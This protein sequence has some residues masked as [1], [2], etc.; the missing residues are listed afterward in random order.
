MKRPDP[1]AAAWLD[2]EPEPRTFSAGPW[3]TTLRGT[4]LED[5]SHRGRYLLSAL[6]VVVRDHDW[7]TVPDRLLTA[8]ATVDEHLRLVLRVEHAGLDAGVRWC[9]TLST[10]GD[11]LRF[12]VDGEVTAAFRRNRV[13]L[14]V[15]HPAEVAGR[16]LQVLHPDG[17]RT[18]TA[19]PVAIAPH[20]PAREV[21]GLVWPV[22]GAE[23]A[24]SLAGDVFEVED[25][26]N[27]TDASFKTYST[28]LDLPFPVA[29]APGDRFTQA[30]ELVVTERPAGASAARA[31]ERAPVPGRSTGTPP[32]P[33]AVA[34]APTGRAVPELQ[35]GACTA[36]GDVR[37]PAPWW[38]GPVLVELDATGRAWPGLL[39]R[40]RREAAGAPLDVRIT[41]QR[42][43]QLDPVLA[44]L[45]AGAAEAAG[46][47]ARVGAY[48]T[49]G[50]VTTP[51]LWRRLRERAGDLPLVG[52]TRAHFTELNRRHG[53]L[54][55]DLPALTFS[56]T[57]QM[58]DTG[59]RQLLESIPVQRATAEQAVRIATGRP[60]HVGPVTLRPRFNAVATSARVP[61]DGEVA[62]GGTGPQHVWQADDPRQASRAFAAWLLASVQAFTVAGVASIT[63][64]ET[65]GPRGFGTL[66][67]AAFPAAEPL[68]RL[69]SAGGWQV[70]EAPLLPGL[71][72]VAACRGGQVLLLA[73]DLSGAGQ[74]LLVAGRPVRVP[75]W[76][77]VHHQ[78]AA[79]AASGFPALPA[80]LA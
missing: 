55:P 50:H 72:L 76:G 77:S 61:A 16:P 6:R 31:P 80:G 58:H 23:A 2:D 8:E 48:D 13:G 14:V 3:S 74:D 32:G 51:A 7:R 1:A 69:R 62:A 53:D 24:L 79:G 42:P 15:L 66:Q 17:S 9:G 64:A 71:G 22:E 4:S 43:E 40:A 37:G 26:R 27:W 5:V 75:P 78:G 28:P 34:L 60:V 63:V 19:F 56:S 47:V 45:R 49:D 44:A 59:R 35:L 65:R 20:Q 25:Q 41:A 54:P 46:P 10:D 57:P 70:L 52:G 30:A 36:P 73:A 68:G 12:V 38:H 11:R 21:A 39:D 29:L 33:L 67:G 18:G